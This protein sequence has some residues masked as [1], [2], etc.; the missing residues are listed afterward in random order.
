VFLEAS[1]NWAWM[2]I[3]GKGA[4]HLGQSGAITNTSILAARD[5]LQLGIKFRPWGALKL[6]ARANYA[7]VAVG[8]AIEGFLMLKR[9]WDD[10]KFREMRDGVVTALREQRGALLDTLKADDFINLYFPQL[11]QME[12]LF[13]Q[14]R[15]A[16]EAARA[17]E[18]AIRDWAE[19][20][21]A[22]CQRF[23]IQAPALP[24][25]SDG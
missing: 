12:T 17:Y 24:D 16:A 15:Q 18:A 5:A 14:I 6:A 8:P 13:E 22:L 21:R 4:A 3:I 19:K 7:L 25:E 23:G 10:K 11:V 2:R 9:W 20:G 1:A